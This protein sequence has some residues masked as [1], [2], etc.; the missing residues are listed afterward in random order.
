MQVG[1]SGSFTATTVSISSS[2]GAV[3]IAGGLGVGGS[4]YAGTSVYV[5][6]RVGYVNSSNASVAYQFYN[7]ATNSID[8]V[9]G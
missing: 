1:A 9:F 3:T 4:M 6:N 8:T 5:G 7:T 2:T